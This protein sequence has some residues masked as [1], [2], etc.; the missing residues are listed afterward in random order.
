MVVQ[1]RVMGPEQIA[2][3]LHDAADLSCAPIVRSACSSAAQSHISSRIGPFPS[4][5]VIVD[6]LVIRNSF[7][8]PVFT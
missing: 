8:G 5:R 6:S 7:S 2:D 4:F 3:S 1:H